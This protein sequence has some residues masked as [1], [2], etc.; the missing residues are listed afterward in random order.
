MDPYGVPNWVSFGLI[1]SPKIKN[2]LEERPFWIPKFF[3]PPEGS[4]LDGPLWG[5]K[6][7]LF[8]INITERARLAG[9]YKKFNVNFIKEIP[10]KLIRPH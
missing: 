7:S 4:S 2:T 9:Q 6:L 1:S 8:R 10:Y 5:P 3:Y